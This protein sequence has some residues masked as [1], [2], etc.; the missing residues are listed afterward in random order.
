M[1][2]LF[3][4][5]NIDNQNNTNTKK[6]ISKELVEIENQESIEQ[7]NRSDRS[8][9]NITDLKTSSFPSSYTD[10]RKSMQQIHT[11]YQSKIQ[12]SVACQMYIKVLHNIVNQL[13]EAVDLAKSVSTISIDNEP[14]NI[15]KN[16]LANINLDLAKG[17]GITIEGYD[18][19]DSEIQTLSA[20]SKSI[21]AKLE[22][23]ND[24]VFST[25]VN[26]AKSMVIEFQKAWTNAINKTNEN[27]EEVIVLHDTLGRI[28][29]GINLFGIT[30]DV[31]YGEQSIELVNQV[32]AFFEKMLAAIKK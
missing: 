19:L 31:D 29:T 16:S 23:L 5:N 6:Q 17:T 18:Q 15:V 22:A 30:V 2:N 9:N 12:P 3:T 26:A 7:E 27:S 8:L 28:A 10:K 11:T 24:T 1:N 13:Q 14:E 32:I 20:N 4:I 21:S 25:K